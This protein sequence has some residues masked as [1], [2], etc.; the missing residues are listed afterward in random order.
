M[1]PQCDCRLLCLYSRWR[2]RRCGVLRRRSVLRTST[3]ECRPAFAVRR[4]TARATH[5]SNTRSARHWD[6]TS[7]GTSSVLVGLCFR[8]F[9]WVGGFD[10][11][12]FWEADMFFGWWGIRGLWMRN[13]VILEF[14]AFYYK[15]VPN[16]CVLWIMPLLSGLTF[17][18]F[19]PSCELISEQFYCPS[20][21][22]LKQNFFPQLKIC[23]KNSLPNLRMNFT[24][25][26]YVHSF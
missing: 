8:V 11:N 9:R 1:Q 5:S 2:A 18:Q 22:F 24:F 23:S 3:V 16:S 25:H 21:Q 26:D 14:L 12:W 10:W 7:G 6:T 19:D 13:S 17:G 4:P 15:P 20:R